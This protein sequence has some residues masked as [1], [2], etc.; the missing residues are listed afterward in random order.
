M[1]FLSNL[2]QLLILYIIIISFFVIFIFN[3][4]IISLVNQYN[5]LYILVI[6]KIFYLI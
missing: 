1:K 5:I 4:I 3:F 2:H 6:I